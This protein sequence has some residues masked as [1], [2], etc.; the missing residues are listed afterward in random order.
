MSGSLLSV[1]L[2]IIVLIGLGVTVFYC[3]RLSKALNNFRKYRQEFNT[4]VGE[5]G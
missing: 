3:I 5:L 4:L 2:D 1:A